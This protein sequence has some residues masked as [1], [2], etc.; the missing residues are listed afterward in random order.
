MRDSMVDFAT[1]ICQNTPDFMQV[2][3]VPFIQGLAVEDSDKEILLGMFAACNT[4]DDFKTIFI[5]F[6]N[7]IAYL[8]Q[9]REWFVCC[10]I[11]VRLTFW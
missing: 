9:G 6:C 8:F 1:F 4:A 3:F 11:Y 2:L 10:K 7:D 5:T